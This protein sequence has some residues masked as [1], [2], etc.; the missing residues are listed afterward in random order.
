M[1]LL[2]LKKLYG[3]LKG[4]KQL[5]SVQ[6][7]ITVDVISDYNRTVDKVGDILNE[8]TSMYNVVTFHKKPYS[9]TITFSSF[10]NDK[11]Y[12]F[13]SYLEYGYNLDEKIIEIGSL[14]NS[15]HDA[16][17]KGRCSDIL[18]AP[19]NFDRVIN[20]ATQILEDRIRKKSENTEGLTGTSLVNKV[21][22][23]DLSKSILIT[24]DVKEEHE[25]IGH[26]CRGIMLSYRNPTHHHLTNNISRAEAL[27]ITGFIDILLKVIDESKLAG[28]KM[29][30]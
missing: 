15:I 4:F 6:R 25:G 18:S 29:K 23:A 10:L 24:S 22:N 9:D 30:K 7:E 20:Q 19:S 2:A 27:R 5:T 13:I 8:D 26:I 1:D 21:L 16:E 12:Q 17:L 3:R 14:F 28:Q 11:L